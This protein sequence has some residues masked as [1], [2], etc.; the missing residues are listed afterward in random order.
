MS[1]PGPFGILHLSWKVDGL[2]HCLNMIWQV[3][4]EYGSVIKDQK[5]IHCLELYNYFLRLNK[6]IPYKLRCM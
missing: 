6:S 3:G 1:H 5:E 2:Q 4:N